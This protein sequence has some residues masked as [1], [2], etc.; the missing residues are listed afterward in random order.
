MRK[1]N[2]EDGTHIAINNDTKRM[3]KHLLIALSPIIIFSFYKNGIIPYTQNSTGLLGMF[4]PLILIFV[5]AS[6]SLISEAIYYRYFLNKKNQELKEALQNSFSFIPG[7]FLGLILPLNTPLA[8]VIFGAVFATIIGKMIFGGFGNN[9]F[10][11]ALVGRLFVFSAYA[12]TIVN[13]GGYL[14]PYEVDTIAKATPL[15]NAHLVTGLGTY[16][17]L[18]APYG[19]LWN[20]FWG[21]IPGSLGETSALLCIAGFIYLTYQK[22]IKWKIP[23]VYILTVFCITFLIG[24]YNGLGIWYPL[25]QIFSG[26]LMFGAVFMA[27]DPVTSPTTSVGQILYGLFLGILTVAFRFLTPEPE[28]VLTSILTMNLFIFIIDRIGA[29]ARISFRKSLI[30]FLL[31]WFLIVGLGLYI[32]NIYKTPVTNVDKN[33]AIISKTVSGLDTIYV[34]TEKGYMSTLKGQ[35]VINNGTVTSFTVLYQG[36]SFYSK[37][38]SANYTSTLISG[39]KNLTDVNTVSGATYTSRGL[40]NM[41]INTLGDYNAK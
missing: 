37:V 14:N 32:A 5:A 28:G 27:T 7:L 6:T 16:Q 21:T 31:A 4:W 18:V 33:F 25:F 8:I 9:V 39:Q 30:P 34:V 2:V 41:L 1:F 24:N 17:T 11:P 23:V 13:H 40:K 36:D 19:N 3:M 26:G 20:F 29:K 35:I 12:L 15:T 38:E 10:N 22:I